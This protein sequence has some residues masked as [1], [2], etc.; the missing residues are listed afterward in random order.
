MH[1]FLHR[2][3]GRRI[4][5]NYKVL[6]SFA[7]EHPDLEEV[8]GEVCDYLLWRDPLARTVS[9]FFDKCRDAID[10]DFVQ[11]VQVVLMEHLELSRVEELRS[12][13]FSEVVRLLPQLVDQEEHFAPQLRGVDLAKVGRVVDIASGLGH[14]ER[15][16]GLSFARRANTSPHGRVG[17]YY[18][19]R[20]RE[21]VQGLYAGDYVARPD[22]G[23]Y[24]RCKRL[25]GFL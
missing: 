11:E 21:I 2:P 25:L 16:T 9:M 1:V 12:V 22:V 20:T 4:G 17:T 8:G 5:L 6:F 14:I 3:S 18:T 7:E 13:T 23:L 24:G 10:P 19:R 15:E